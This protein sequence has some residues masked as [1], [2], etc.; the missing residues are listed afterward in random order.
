[1]SHLCMGE[2]IIYVTWSIDLVQRRLRGQKTLPAYI[3]TKKIKMLLELL[4]LDMNPTKEDLGGTK[5]SKCPVM[6]VYMDRAEFAPP[7]VKLSKQY[8]VSR[9][10]LHYEGRNGRQKF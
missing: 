1:M 8:L 6:F 3:K 4:D 10:L 5:S 7:P 9:S 2:Q